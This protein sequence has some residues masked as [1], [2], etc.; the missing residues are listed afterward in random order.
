MR[1]LARVERSSKNIMEA[2]RM[3]TD[4]AESQRA[5]AAVSRDFASLYDSSTG[6]MSEVKAFYEQALRDSEKMLKEND[7]SKIKQKVHQCEE[8]LQDLE[9]QIDVNEQRLQALAKGAAGYTEPGPDAGV[10]PTADVEQQLAVLQSEANE[11]NPVL[12]QVEEDFA[13]FNR[14][15]GEVE[16]S[17]TE[18]RQ[19]LLEDIELRATERN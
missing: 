15:Q 13:A 2:Q 16:C 17:T 18:D 1:Q 4:V 8:D 14:L 3:L 19:R 6:Q 11:V 12:K 9:R 5:F 10:P 7:S